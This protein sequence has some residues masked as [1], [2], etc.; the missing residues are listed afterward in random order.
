MKRRVRLLRRAKNDVRVITDWI[1]ERSKPGAER[2]VAALDRAL[3]SIDEF[4]ESH[5]LAE[6]DDAFPN[7][8]IRQFLFKTR[9]GRT[10]RGLFI[11]VG[12][13]KSVLRV[14]GPGQD[15]ITPEEVDLP[16][17]RHSEI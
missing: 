14:R 2:L 13:E 12:D 8:T 17:D 3:D 16:D 11:V 4:P 10:Y 7:H 9:R 1:A 5:P 15:L 6:D